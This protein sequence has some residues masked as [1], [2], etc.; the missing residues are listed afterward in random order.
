MLAQCSLKSFTSYFAF[1]L[2]CNQIYHATKSISVYRR[3]MTRPLE[4]SIDFALFI[5]FQLGACHTDF[6]CVTSLIVTRSSLLLYINPVLLS[7]QVGLALDQES[8]RLNKVYNRYLLILHCLQVFNQVRVTQIL[9]VLLIITRS[10]LHQCTSSHQS[11]IIILNVGR[12][13]QN[14]QPQIKNLLG[15]NNRTI[16]GIDMIYI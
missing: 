7:M 5:G 14:C 6:N 16:V 12:C 1:K 4:I 9:I 11:R 15:L 2:N 10:S 3:E 13:S 8:S